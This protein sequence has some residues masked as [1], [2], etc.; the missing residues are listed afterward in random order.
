MKLRTLLLICLTALLLAASQAS[1]ELFI[2]PTQDAPMF[3]IEIPD[4]WKSEVI[5]ETILQSVSPDE[6]V[7]MMAWPID[8][9]TME[10]AVDGL[11]EFLTDLLTDIT[12]DGE[13]ETLDIN[14]IPFWRAT[15]QGK[16]V[17]TDENVKLTVGF[18][19]LAED[20]V[21]LIA[22]LAEP[23]AAQ[24]HAESIAAIF[25]SIKKP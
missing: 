3:T 6:K 7:Y 25:Q 10:E 2:Y 14:G 4:K 21:C 16:D 13:G 8:A 23:K 22:F 24:R 18:F 12:L 20:T 11:E 17:E 9:E 5:E 19:V 15:G 1:A